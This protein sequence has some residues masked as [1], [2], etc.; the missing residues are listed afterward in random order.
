LKPEAHAWH[1]WLGPLEEH[2]RF[3][4]R[5]RWLSLVRCFRALTA[6][7]SSSMKRTA[8]LKG[9]VYLIVGP[10]GWAALALIFAEYARSFLPMS[11][12][13]VRI[14]AAVLI[15]ILALMGCRSASLAAWVQSVATWTKVAALV[16]MAVALLVLGGQSNSV[17]IH[18]L[19][20]TDLR[21]CHDDGVR[22]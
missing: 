17:K 7:T 19:L 14:V 18:P 20:S 5:Y 10:S 15:A 11:E 16:C 3:A 8:F 4:D 9:W 6:C 13:G 21:R 22:N 2:L 1:C 12:I